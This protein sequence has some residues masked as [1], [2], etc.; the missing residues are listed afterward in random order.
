MKTVGIIVNTSK[1]KAAIVAI[2]VK[3]WL[4]SSRITSLIPDEQAS[5]LNIPS[6]GYTQEQVADMSDAL[7]VLGGDGTILRAAHIPHVENVPILGVNLGHLGYLT[8]VALD[9]LYS[10]LNNLL[11][12]NYEIEERMMLRVEVYRHGEMKMQSF[13]LNDLVI[14]HPM[15]MIQIDA[16]I[17]G[18]YFVTYNGDG[19]IIATPTGSTAYSLSEG[20]PIV[21]PNMDAFILT[22]I[23]S[24]A[25]T[26]RPF[27]A[28]A[29][30]RISVIIRSNYE[31]IILAVDNVY[32]TREMLSFD[33]D[34]EIV[35]TK[36]EKTIK[37]IKSLNRSYYEALRAKL[38]LGDRG[39]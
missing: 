31:D 30:S 28:N 12:G 4:K 16:Y 6:D 1:P 33:P 10:A 37:L 36:A 32:W 26:L 38:K 29:N 8:E 5:E 19:L 34:S 18:E 39:E 27:I 22:P 3:D 24:H 25:L 23:A 21:A 9:E 2:E 13:A 15:Q 17:D 7:I 11:L 20:G 35:V 14:K